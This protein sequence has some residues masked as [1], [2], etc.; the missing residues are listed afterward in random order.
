[1][2]KIKHTFFASQYIFILT[3]INMVFLHKY[4]NFMMMPVFL[5]GGKMKITWFW[6]SFKSR[7]TCLE[8]VSTRTKQEKVKLKLNSKWNEIAKC[9]NFL[10]WIL[11]HELHKTAR[12]GLKFPRDWI[13]ASGGLYDKQKWSNWTQQKESNTICFEREGNSSG[14]NKERSWAG[15]PGLGLCSKNPLREIKDLNKALL[16]ISLIHLQYGWNIQEQE[17]A[18]QPLNTWV[19]PSGEIVL[20]PNGLESVWE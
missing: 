19:W 13:K 7:R 12:S 2:P 1:M 10:I 14:S 6:M 4:Y 11:I 20:H 18:F 15:K 9:I 17:F 16:L 5:F 3:D 8:G